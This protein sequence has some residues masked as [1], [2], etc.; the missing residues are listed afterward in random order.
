M[1][2]DGALN[3]ES[4]SGKIISLIFVYKSWN[5]FFQIQSDKLKLA[6][7]IKAGN[8]GNTNKT[9]NMI[10]TS[11]VGRASVAGTE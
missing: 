10:E 3:Q 4:I 9:G 5:F 7:Y 1:E 11:N 8:L 6:M 2:Y